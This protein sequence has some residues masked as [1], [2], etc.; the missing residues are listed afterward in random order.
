[1]CAEHADLP[2]AAL[3]VINV[4][5]DAERPAAERLVAEVRRLRDDA[6]VKRD[7]LGVMAPRRQPTV[8][9]AN[10]TDPKD[11]GLKKVVTRV[12]RTIS[13]AAGA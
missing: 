11:A 9:V 6:E 13:R 1:M 12:R 7:V 4:H 10:L 5:D 8:V 2:S 3:V